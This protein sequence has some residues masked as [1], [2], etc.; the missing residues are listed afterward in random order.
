MQLSKAEQAWMD[1]I[2]ERARPHLEAGKSLPEAI[3][4]AHADLQAFAG[5]MAVGE[6]PRAK[7]AARVLSAAV[8]QTVNVGRVRRE[9]FRAAVAD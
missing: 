6:T 7:R 2:A 3:E 5:E 8:W 4:A 1:Q 9:A